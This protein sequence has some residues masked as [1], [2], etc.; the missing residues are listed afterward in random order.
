MTKFQKESTVILILAFCAGNGFSITITG[1]FFSDPVLILGA[2]IFAISMLGLVNATRPFEINYDKK[3]TMM[4]ASKPTTLDIFKILPDGTYSI[5]I[6]G[7]IATFYKS[8]WDQRDGE[9]GLKEKYLCSWSIFDDVGNEKTLNHQS[10]D[11]QK[12][13]KKFVKINMEK[14]K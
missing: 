13:V 9:N 6:K 8:Y 2:V 1:L 12:L 10:P 7:N 11:M 5:V 4:V 14:K 3:T